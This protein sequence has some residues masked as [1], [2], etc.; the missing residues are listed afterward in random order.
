[1][2][3]WNI[4]ENIDVVLL[5]ANNGVFQGVSP[6]TLYQGPAGPTPAIDAVFELV[7]EDADGDGIPG[8]KMIDGPFIDFRANFNL[9]FTQSS[10][11]GEVVAEESNIKSPGL[12]STAGGCT[13]TS[14]TDS[15]LQRG[16]W[17]AV[18][19]FVALLGFA[20]NRKQRKK[21][22]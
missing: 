1:L 10:G 14:A 17:L 20:G 22:Q 11:G 2:F 9:N 13:L 4:T 12:G 21:L 16:D 15:P 19:G 3:D 5:W 8:A 7:S 6:G 18:L